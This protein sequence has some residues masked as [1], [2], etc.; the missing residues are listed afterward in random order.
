MPAS[1]SVRVSDLHSVQLEMRFLSLSMK[2]NEVA[3]SAPQEESRMLSSHSCKWNV[4]KSICAA[5]RITP[6][7]LVSVPHSTTES[8]VA[9]VELAVIS[10]AIVGGGDGLSVVV[11][12]AVVVLCV[13]VLS[14][15]PLPAPP[16]PPPTSVMMVVK[17]PGLPA[18]LVILVV[19]LSVA[20][21]DS[22]TVV[23]VVILSV[24]SAPTVLMGVI[25]V[26]GKPLQMAYPNCMHALSC[27]SKSGA[28]YRAQLCRLAYIGFYFLSLTNVVQIIVIMCIK[29]Q[30][31]IHRFSCRPRQ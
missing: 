28:I 21:V 16:P 3:Y 5:L 7:I 4:W 27:H 8:L 23:G 24:V 26:V 12:V 10:I 19:A 15:G 17:V 11:M 1:T 18:V 30:K 20:V 6:V 31:I 14:R 2:Y 9:T 13:C 22:V 25:V 29:K